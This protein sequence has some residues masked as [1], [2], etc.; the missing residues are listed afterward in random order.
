MKRLIVLMVIALCCVA[1]YAWNE[2]NSDAPD[3]TYETRTLLQP[4]RVELK[5]AVCNGNMEYV[6]RSAFDTYVIDDDIFHYHFY[7]CPACG[8]HR[9][10]MVMA[11]RVYPYIDYVEVE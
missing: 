10:A 1:T 11:K 5:C 9:D 6:G 2:T 4:Y 7:T 8:K 3:G